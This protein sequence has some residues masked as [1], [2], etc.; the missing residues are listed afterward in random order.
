LNASLPRLDEEAGIR[1]FIGQLRSR[2]G[3]R[4]TA[5]MVVTGFQGE[6]MHIGW[7]KEW[8]QHGNDIGRFTARAEQMPHNLPSTTK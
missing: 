4:V 3:G 2:K 5:S 8:E 1:V 7:Q 6:M